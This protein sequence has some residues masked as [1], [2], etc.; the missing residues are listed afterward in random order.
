MTHEEILSR[1]KMK[2]PLAEKRSPSEMA[3]TQKLDAAISDALGTWRGS[4]IGKDMLSLLKTPAD[5][6]FTHGELD[7]AGWVNT[8]A[9]QANLSFKSALEQIF[10][11]LKRHPKALE[12]YTNGD[13]N[14]AESADGVSGFTLPFG[15]N[16]D[17]QVMKTF[18][19]ARV[20]Q[21]AHPACDLLG[22]VVV[23]GKKAG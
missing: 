15:W 22:A 11:Y 13:A 18:R 17:Q 8:Y 21:A 2:L 1:L 12:H 9:E 14:F 4:T 3:S 20:Y 16:V 6:V 23:V 10:E 7:L 5:M 19:R